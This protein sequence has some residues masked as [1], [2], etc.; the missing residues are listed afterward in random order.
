VGLRTLEEL[1]RLG[2]EVMVVARAPAPEEADRARELGAS[3]IEGAHRQE[4]VLRAA[5]IETAAALVAT[6]DDDIGNLYAALVAHDLNRV[7]ASACACSTR[8]P[9]AETV[10]KG[11]HEVAVVV[12]RE[13]LAQVLAASEAEAAREVA[14]RQA[15]P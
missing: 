10:I 4:A 3:L 14:G 2:D 12:T 7:C 5:G 9:P 15:G 1:R 6:E 8:R 13:G 11:G